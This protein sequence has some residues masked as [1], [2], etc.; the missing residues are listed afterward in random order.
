[1][2]QNIAERVGVLR[3]GR[4]IKNAGNTP[5]WCGNLRMS[6]RMLPGAPPQPITMSIREIGLIG[7]QIHMI[8]VFH[9]SAW[10]QGWDVGLGFEVSGS[11]YPDI[12]GG[13]PRTQISGLGDHID[14]IFPIPQNSSRML[15]F[16]R[17]ALRRGEL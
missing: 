10:W 2:Q 1:M 11:G 4:N 3:I 16:Y 9:I 7:T 8:H 5:E 6:V 14:C 15:H 13:P 17:G 12:W